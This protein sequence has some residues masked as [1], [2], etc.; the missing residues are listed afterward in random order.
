MIYKRKKKEVIIELNFKLFKQINSGCWYYEVLIVT[1]GVMQIGWATKDSNF[2]SDDGY[3]IGDDKYSIAFDGCRRLIWHHAK[4][5]AHNL[6]VW[7][8]GSIL[9]CL[10]DLDNYEVIFSLDGV[11]S[12]VFKQVFRHAK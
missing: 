1:P 8:S 6:P 3:G 11:E 9:G 2:L 7:H 12:G 10:I 4:S 5:T